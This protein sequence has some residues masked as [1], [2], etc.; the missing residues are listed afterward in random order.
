MLPKGA[1]IAA[2]ETLQRNKATIVAGVIIAVLVAGVCLFFAGQGAS[3]GSTEVHVHDSDG[4]VHTLDLQQNQTLT[5]QTS[6]GTNVIEV[7]DGSV[8]VIEADCPGG[9]CLRQA[10]ITQPGQQLI[11]LPHQ[12]WVEVVPAGKADGQ[13][14]VNA[15]SPND[16][17]AGDAGAGADSGSDSSSAGSNSNSGSNSDNLDVVAS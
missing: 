2:N 9:D 11:C 14:D 1:L 7:R 8:R 12:L 6:L 16:E 17:D 5:V 4:K 10:A 13:L 15:V 3:G